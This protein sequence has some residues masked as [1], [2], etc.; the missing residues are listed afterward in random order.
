MNIT[1]LLFGIST[2]LVGKSSLTYHLEDKATVK[3]LRNTL[4]LEFR[5]LKN[6]HEF[7]IAV[8]E[9]YANDDLILKNGDIV[10][11]I[12]PVSGG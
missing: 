5:E 3:D 8:N 7:A 4:K 2:D 10:A 1:I 9:E 11:I 6:I 12:P